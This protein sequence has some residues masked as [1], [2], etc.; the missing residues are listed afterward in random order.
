M[1]F[2]TIANMRTY[3]ATNA[4]NQLLPVTLLTLAVSATAQGFLEL[5]ATATPSAELANYHLRPFMQTNS[6]VQMFFDAQELGAVQATLDELS[7]RFDGPIPQVGAPGPFQIQ[8]LV[9]QVGVTTVPQPA[10]RFAA[11]LSQ[12]LTTV[13][14]S[15]W[16]Y[17][18]D[19]GTAFPHPW[20]GVNDGLRFPFTTPVTVTVPPGAWLVIDLQ[21]TG[22][23][24]AN[25]GFSHAIVDGVRATGGIADGTA[26]SYGQGC[27]NGTSTSAA[28][29]GGSGTYA[30]GGAHFVSGQ[31]LGANAPVLVMFGLSDAVSPV[32]ALPYNLAGTTCDLLTSFD[33]YVL[34]QANAAGAIPAEYAPAA[35]VVPA[36]PAFAGVTLF[37]QLASIVPGANAPWGVALSDGRRI[38]L[39]ALTAPSRG[40]WTVSHG[41]AADATIADRVE[42]FGYAVRLHTR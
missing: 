17:L 34:V 1:R 41:T 6:R 28:A 21:M 4:M 16:T 42:A 38:D 26:T 35:L 24:I 15:P 7:L 33:F 3:S 37:E 11:N 27:T 36:D 10:A 29:I 18:P 40:T 22:N 13:F 19:P 25:F 5:P 8:R 9:I 2:E 32:G 23:N 39:G 14:D 20:G 31:N 12:P 30:P